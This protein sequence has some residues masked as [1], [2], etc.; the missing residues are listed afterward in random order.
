M[1]NDIKRIIFIYFFSLIFGYFIGAVSL[2]LLAVSLAYIFYLHKRTQ[3]ILDSSKRKAFPDPYFHGNQPDILQQLESTLVKL[4]LKDQ[5]R[6]KK[7]RSLLKEFREATK[8]LPYSIIAL[9]YQDCITWTNKT[10]LKQLGIKT[11]DDIGMRITNVLRDPKI[12]ELLDQ[13]EIENIKVKSPLDSE[14]ILEFSCLLYGQ[15]NKLIVARDITNLEM[16]ENMRAAFVANVSHEL[17][18]P[19]T[20]FKGYIEGLNRRQEEIPK[21]WSTPMKEMAEQAEKMSQLVDELLLLSKLQT[22]TTIESHS[23]VNVPVLINQS[24][25]RA[26]KLSSPKKHFY[27]FEISDS[28]I[29]NGI[30]KEIYIIISN[31]IFNAARYTRNNGVIEIKWFAN[32]QG[33]HFQVKDNGVGISKENLPR[34]TERFFRVDSSK[35]DEKEAGKFNNTGLGLALVKHSAIRNNATLKIESKINE[36]SIFTVSFSPSKNG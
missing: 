32:E 16:A 9:D 24:V 11:P 34:V 29:V 1:K 33:I 22:E 2:V 35:S 23:K 10:A 18:S 27:S 12:I 25:A 7:I 19:I 13:K 20:I 6:K 36:G 15:N 3:S 14:K 21:S 26:K 31:I 8:A 4:R 17:R 30:E 5:S 28:L